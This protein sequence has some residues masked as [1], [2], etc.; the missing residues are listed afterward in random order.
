MAAVA[1]PRLLYGRDI[2]VTRTKKY[3]TSKARLAAILLILKYFAK[4]FLC[5]FE[6]RCRLRQLRLRR[7]KVTFQLLDLLL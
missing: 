7:I 3:A 2:N 4:F 1:R 6:L 5:V